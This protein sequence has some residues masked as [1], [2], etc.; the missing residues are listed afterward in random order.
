LIRGYAA[1]LMALET[2]ADL[3]LQDA[4]VSGLAK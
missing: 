3:I 1:V 2:G 4:Q